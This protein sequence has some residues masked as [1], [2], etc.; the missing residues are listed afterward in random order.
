MPIAT[1]INSSSNVPIWTSLVRLLCTAQ[2]V[3]A[4]TRNRNILGSN[5]CSGAQFSAVNFTPGSNPGLVT[6]FILLPPPYHL[7]ICHFFANHNYTTTQVHKYMDTLALRHATTRDSTVESMKPRGWVTVL[8]SE[9]EA[10]EYIADSNDQHRWSF[11]TPSGV[12]W[13]ENI[14]SGP[15]EIHYHTCLINNMQFHW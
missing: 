14:L 11:T 6:A 1:V 5:F 8:F 12:G 10:A 9:R 15:L 3:E 4:Q 2:L 13:G 7:I